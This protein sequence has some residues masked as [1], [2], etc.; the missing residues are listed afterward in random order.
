MLTVAEAQ[1]LFRLY[2][3]EHN[4]FC[5][6]GLTGLLTGASAATLNTDYT[7]IKSWNFAS[8]IPTRFVGGPPRCRAYCNGTLVTFLVDRIMLCHLRYNTP[9]A[10]LV[11]FDSTATK[12]IWTQLAD[13]IPKNMRKYSVH[14]WTKEARTQQTLFELDDSVLELGTLAVMD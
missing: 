9:M 7:W 8:G 12:A 2:N 4:E 13:K 5:L 11:R 10:W 6:R 3:A 14:P 1:W